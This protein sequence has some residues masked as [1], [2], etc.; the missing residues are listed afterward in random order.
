[1]KRKGHAKVYVISDDSL[2]RCMDP[3]KELEYTLAHD[4][5]VR[6]KCFSR[7]DLEGVAVDDR[8]PDWQVN[9]ALSEAMIDICDVVAVVGSKVTPSM[10]K[11]IDFASG[12]GKKICVADSIRDIVKM[13]N[14]R[15]S[16][17]RLAKVCK[18]ILGNNGEESKCR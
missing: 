3:V 16:A 18:D 8:G 12:Y 9:E 1:M 14:I 11:E 13:M 6:A 5:G 10:K 15:V 2:R 7:A 17:D 4:Y